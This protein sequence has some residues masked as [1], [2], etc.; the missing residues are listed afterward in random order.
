MQVVLRCQKGG[1]DPRRSMRREWKLG[2]KIYYALTLREQHNELNWKKIT[3]KNFDRFRKGVV[4]ELYCMIAWQISKTHARTR[5]ITTEP[6]T[7]SNYEN[8]GRLFTTS[9]LLHEK[10]QEAIY[11]KEIVLRFRKD[12]QSEKGWSFDISSVMRS[13]GVKVTVL[14]PRFVPHPSG[15]MIRSVARACSGVCS[16]GEI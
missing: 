11:Q 5:E 14:M 9:L 1:H 16:S 12:I 6:C 13:S 10:E 15:D 4:H 8:S 2:T 3:H 7:S